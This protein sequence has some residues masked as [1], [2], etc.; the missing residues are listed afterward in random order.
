M[1]SR[2]LAYIK[3]FLYLCAR[4]CKLNIAKRINNNKN[5]MLM[6]KQFQIDMSRI[7]ELESKEYLTPEEFRE[8]GHFR[9]SQLIQPR[10]AC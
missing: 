7:E 8:L 6:K 2:S 5:L 1:H 4:F 10:V 9:M 3:I